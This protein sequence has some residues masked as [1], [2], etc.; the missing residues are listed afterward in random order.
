MTPEATIPSEDDFQSAVV[1]ALRL[2]LEAHVQSGVQYAILEPFGLD[3]AIL[4]KSPLDTALRLIEFKA[5][6]GQRPGG[7][8]FGNQ[9]GKVLRLICSCCRIPSCPR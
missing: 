2:R 5:Y 3:A 4:V 8:G 9:E 1:S 7:I 6:A